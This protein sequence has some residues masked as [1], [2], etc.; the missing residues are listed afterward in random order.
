MKAAIFYPVHARPGEWRAT[1]GALSARLVSSGYTDF[2]RAMLTSESDE[3]L[4]EL[5]PGE[6]GQAAIWVENSC[7]GVKLARSVYLNGWT[8]T[9]AGEELRAF[10]GARVIL[11]TQPDDLRGALLVFFLASEAEL[12]GGALFSVD[13]AD[14]LAGSDAALSDDEFNTEDRK[15]AFSIVCARARAEAE[16]AEE[17]LRRLERRAAT[18]AASNFMEARV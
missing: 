6:N 4:P 17:R 14:V 1:D 2:E 9:L 16:F 12:S 7:V 18:L 10:G 8:R 13:F 5:L 3:G 11:S 15:L